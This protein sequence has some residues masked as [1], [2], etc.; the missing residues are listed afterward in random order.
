MQEWD[1]S[2]TVLDISFHLSALPLTSLS[3]YIYQAKFYPWIIGALSLVQEQYVLV[4]VL[5]ISLHLSV[6][7]LTFMSKHIE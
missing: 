3:K 1:L 4:M 7:P 2:E 5:V 6:S